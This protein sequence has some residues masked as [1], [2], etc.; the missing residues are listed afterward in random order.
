[1]IDHVKVA[2][3]ALKL[4]ML[5]STCVEL[6]HLDTL[7]KMGETVLTLTNVTPCSLVIHKFDALIC[8]QDSDVKHARKASMDPIIK[9]SSW[10]Q[11]SINHS[12][13]NAVKIS[14][15][16]EKEQ[17]TVD[18][19]RNVS[20]KQDLLSVSVLVDSSDQIWQMSALQFQDFVLM[21]S[22]FVIEMPFVDH[23]VEDVTDANAKLA[24]LVMVSAVEVIEIWMVGP[25]KI[26]NV[27]VHFADKTI[28]PAFL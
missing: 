28:V 2:N 13:D 22:P 3:N 6:V 18:P 27:Q 23:L 17:Q 8:H 25:I 12:K 26:W 20:T 5:R 1:M 24:L 19:I 14:T 16:V 9:D 4:L 21:A 11:V 15:S 7:A 10:T